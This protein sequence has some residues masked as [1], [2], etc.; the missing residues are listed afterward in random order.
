VLLGA[1]RKSSI[2]LLSN[3]EPPKD[4]LAGSIALLC[5]AN[6]FGTQIIR[7]HDVLESKQAISIS[8]SLHKQ[9]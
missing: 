1:S 8:S 5:Y 2:A 3:N 9:I 7:V 4:R 6:L